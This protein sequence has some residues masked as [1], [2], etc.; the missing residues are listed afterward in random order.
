[1]PFEKQQILISGVGGQ[2]ILFITRVLAE[3]AIYKGYP[4]L[5]AETHGM[6]QRGGIVVSHIKVGGFSS[7][8]IRPGKAD[9][10]LLLTEENLQ[11]HLCYLGPDGIAV[12]NTRSQPEG[13]QNLKMLL[14][15]ADGLANEVQQ[16]KSVNLALAG[17]AFS[18]LIRT[19]RQAFC[20][21]D[22]IRAVLHQKLAGRNE[23]LKASLSV[24]DLGVLRGEKVNI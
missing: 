14:I 4:V 12:V 22:D 15:D 24:F 20:S 10:L 21:P 17:F 23:L 5:T 16:P 9:V 7:P 6:A 8:L 11:N 2:G 3:A 18:A 1:M 13:P 19:S